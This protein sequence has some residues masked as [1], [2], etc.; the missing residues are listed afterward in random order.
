VQHRGEQWIAGV[1]LKGIIEEWRDS[2]CR[3]RGGGGVGVCA[4][5]GEG[6]TD[7]QS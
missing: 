1:L 4:P 6:M 2:P 3:E 5:L 7:F